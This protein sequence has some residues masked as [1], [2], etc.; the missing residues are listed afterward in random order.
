MKLSQWSEKAIDGEF[1]FLKT[2][3]EIRCDRNAM[4]FLE[5]AHAALSNLSSLRG[6]YKRSLIHYAAMGN[7]TELLC[8]LL[9]QGVSINDRDGNRRTP[10]SWAAEYGALEAVKILLANGAKVN[11]TDDM[12]ATPLTWVMQVGSGQRVATEAYLRK[13]GAR[14]KGN[15]RRWIW[16]RLGIAPD[17]VGVGFSKI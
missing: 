2:F 10:L 5:H 14:E 3:R 11:A 9:L 8:F 13:H 4:A 1:Q 15:R 12:F 7:C 16:R 6:P 17:G